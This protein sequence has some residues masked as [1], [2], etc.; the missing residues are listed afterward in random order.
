MKWE[1]YTL[2]GTDVALDII[3]GEPLT[4]GADAGSKIVA[5]TCGGV[6]FQVELSPAATVARW[7]EGV[8]A[9]GADLLEQDAGHALVALHRPGLSGER[10]IASAYGRTHRGVPLL[11]T[12]QRPDENWAG[13]VEH[14]VLVSLAP[15]VRE[16]LK[17][18]GRDCPP[19]V[20]PLDGAA[21]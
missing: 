10:L 9:A 2:P 6:S 21:P 4:I 14:H 13:D 19:S 5:Q 7:L 15:P 17:G 16:D 8:I 20:T 18:D 1:R 3:A 11:V 12:F